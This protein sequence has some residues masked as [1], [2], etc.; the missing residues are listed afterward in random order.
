MGR[1]LWMTHD[2]DA[3]YSMPEWADSRFIGHENCGGQERCVACSN[4]GPSVRSRPRR[5]LEVYRWRG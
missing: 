2:G 1:G 3:G 5:A 4:L